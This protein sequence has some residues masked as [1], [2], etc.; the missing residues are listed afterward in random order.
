VR[1]CVPRVWLCAPSVSVSPEQG[2][3]PG[4]V[5]RA[6]GC[7]PGGGIAF[8][9]EIIASGPSLGADCDNC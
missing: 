8:I 6:K 1:L 3:V 7:V 2:C 4:G 5:A 9:G